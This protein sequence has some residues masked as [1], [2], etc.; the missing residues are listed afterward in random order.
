MTR[1]E[2]LSWRRQVVEDL[3]LKPVRADGWA[4][5]AGPEAALIE[6]CAVGEESACAQLVAEHERMVYQLAINLLGDRDEAQ[7]LSQ[8][9][10]LR[11]F[12]TIH[13]FRGQSALRTWIFRIVINQARNRQRWW[14]R[15]NRGQQVSLDDHIQAHGDVPAPRDG[16]EPDR[17][18]ARKELADRIWTAMDALPFEQRTAIVLREVD[19]LSYDEIAFSLGVTLGTVKARLTRARQALRAALREAP[20]P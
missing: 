3:V 12:R 14:R 8:E 7:D 10:F 19:G 15:R 20:Q 17:A 16:T 1:P 13:R 9:V 5:L 4:E 2:V 18:L 11:V 6:R